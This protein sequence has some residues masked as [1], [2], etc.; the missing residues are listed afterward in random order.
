MKGSNFSYKDR[1]FIVAEIGNNHEGNI[2]VAKE[3]IKEASAAGADAVKFQ[4]YIPEK[5]VTSS[6]NKRVSLL[7]KFQLSNNEFLELAEFA[8]QSN[9][10]LFSTPFDLES[11]SFLNTFQGIFKISSGDNNFEPLIEKV[12]EFGKPTIIS[13]GI[14]DLNLIK[15][16]YLNWLNNYSKFPIA[17]LHCVSSYPVPESEANINVIKNMINEFPKATIGYSDHTIGIEASVAAVSLGAKIIEKHFTLDKNYSEFRDH[18]LSSDPKEL[19]ILV[20]SIRKVEKMMGN[21]IKQIQ[22]CEKDIVKAVRRS[23]A[24]KKYMPINHKISWD[25]LTWVRPGIGISPGNEKNLIG[26]RLTK[27]INMGEIILPEMLGD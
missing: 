19:K 21:G 15:N 25:D 6:D 26:K 27:T 9:I 1:V 16:I 14:T 24:A 12:F 18:Q 22:P 10:I 3:L 7:K 8:K 17:F 4:T 23:I 2:E 11:A 5:Y 13:T 20:K